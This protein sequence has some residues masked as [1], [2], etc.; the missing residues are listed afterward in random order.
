MHKRFQ[1]P[2]ALPDEVFA[3]NVR[4]DA[5]LGGRLWFVKSHL[6]SYL[7]WETERLGGIAY[8]TDGL[9]IKGYRPLFVKKAEFQ[10]KFLLD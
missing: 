7:H 10:K 3:V 2:E 5:F 6:F 1:H 8:S 9:Q 4:V